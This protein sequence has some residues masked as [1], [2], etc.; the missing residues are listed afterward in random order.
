LAHL[1]ADGSLPG[2]IAVDGDADR[3]HAC[4]TGTCQLAL[5]WA[6]LH[7]HTGDDR[8]RVAAVRALESVMRCQDVDTEDADVRGAIKGAHPIWAPYAPFAFPNWAA[9]FFVDAMLLCARWL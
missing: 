6:R 4:L 8:F 1:G 5:V 3:S 2:R 7:G 9:K